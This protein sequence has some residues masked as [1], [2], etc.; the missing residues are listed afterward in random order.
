MRVRGSGGA[1]SH[2]MLMPI[3]HHLDRGAS[4]QGRPANND[5]EQHTDTLILY[6]TVIVKAVS[7]RDSR[8][9][10]RRGGNQSTKIH[11]Q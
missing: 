5:G 10:D 8:R 6:C 1:V 2:A 7:G 3:A 11:S 4:A 9:L